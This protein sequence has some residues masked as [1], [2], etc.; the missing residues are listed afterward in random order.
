MTSQ[1]YHLTSHDLPDVTPIELRPWR[2]QRSPVRSAVQKQVKVPS[3]ASHVPPK[4]HGEESQSSGAA[5]GTAGGCV[6]GAAVAVAVAP[7]GGLNGELG[8]SGGRCFM[9]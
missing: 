1:H 9:D 8:E 2:S 7:I 3:C 6:Y 4:R 5:V